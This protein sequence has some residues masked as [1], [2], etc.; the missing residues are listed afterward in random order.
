[1][2]ISSLENER[3]KQ[4]GWRGKN[5]LMVV[6]VKYILPTFRARVNTLKEIAYSERGVAVGGGGGGVGGVSNT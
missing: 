3:G 1:M 2:T 6:V 5:L 4:E